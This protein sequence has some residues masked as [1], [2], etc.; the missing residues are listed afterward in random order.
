MKSSLDIKL[1]AIISITL[2]PDVVRWNLPTIC[3]KVRSIWKYVHL[4]YGDKF[5]WFHIGGDDLLIIPP[6]MRAYL[7]SEEIQRESNN[8]ELGGRMGWGANTSRAP[9]PTNLRP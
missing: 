5:D 9:R 6:N 4:H 3:Q 1:R 8:G 2:L 7:L